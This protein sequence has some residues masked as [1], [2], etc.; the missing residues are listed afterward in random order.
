M[1]AET[2]TARRYA[3]VSGKGGVGKTVITANLAAALAAAGRRT[4]VIDADLGLANLD[5]V[6][7][8]NPKL[9]LH[10][11]IREKAVIDEVVI[12]TPAGFDLL[13]AGSGLVEGTH[14]TPSLAAWV[15]SAI[16]SFDRKYD[17]ILFDAGAG[18]GEVVLFFARL[19]HEILL[20]VTPEPTSITDAYATIKVMAKLYQ[21]TKFDLIVNLA[22]P[23]R[24]SQT[25]SAVT[26][27]LQQVV[28]R[29]LA[30][31][32]P[33]CVRLNLMG[34]VPRD[35]ALPLATSRQQLIICSDPESPA[36]RSIRGLA[37]RLGS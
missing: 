1:T 31:A 6:M 9:T 19:A 23:S 5:I 2:G 14:L 27:H 29:F 8:L 34:S 21:K 16:S 15:E 25:G 17:L 24:P 10:D 28:S 22:N 32:G 36:A 26:G 33:D 7:G 11:V 3:V 12:T 30:D 4:L 37:E 20:V 35:S 18:I 13:P